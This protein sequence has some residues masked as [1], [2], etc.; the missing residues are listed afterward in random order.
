[1]QLEMA[2]LE[3]LLRRHRAIYKGKC[4]R[5]YAIRL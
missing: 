4:V 1:M 2:R 5:S 3:A